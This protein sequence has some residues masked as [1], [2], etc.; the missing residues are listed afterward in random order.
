M[1]D[2]LTTDADVLIRSDHYWRIAVK[3]I[4]GNDEV[5]AVRFYTW[6]CE[7]CGKETITRENMYPGAEKCEVVK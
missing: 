4:I 7:K 3:E 6:R 5:G 1:S 2:K